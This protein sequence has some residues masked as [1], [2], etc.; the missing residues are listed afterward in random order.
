MNNELF[1]QRNHAM[2]FASH[3]RK[4]LE[5]IEMTS[6]AGTHNEVH[7]VTQL[8]NS[9]LGLVVFLWERN[10]VEH[11]KTLPLADLYKEGWPRIE[12]LKGECQTLGDLIYHLRNA[13]A[14]GRIKFSS[15]SQN[16]HDVAIEIE[17]C[18]SRQSIPYWRARMIADD[19]RVFCLKF[20][21]LLDN[22]IG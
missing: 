8:A 22:T 5:Y 16:M 9:L 4:N 14:H 21:D 13:A 7:V 20:I 10:F 11:I 1:V 6:K 19:L 12:M 17:D 15:D 3:T 2:V 18:K